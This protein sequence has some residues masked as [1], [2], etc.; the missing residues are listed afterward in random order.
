MD[1]G[2]F[3]ETKL[4]GGSYTH[5]SSRYSVATDALSRHH[6][7]VAVFYRPPPQYALE[8]IHR[9]GNNVVGFQLATGEQRW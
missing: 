7:G 4:T 1:L 8:A 2:I 6:S 5:R 9:F 3:K